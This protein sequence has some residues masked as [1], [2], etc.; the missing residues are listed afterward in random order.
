MYYKLSTS[1]AQIG[2][3]KRD[4]KIKC[5]PPL[6]KPV[7]FANVRTNSLQGSCKSIVVSIALGELQIAEERDGYKVT[8][9]LTW[10]LVSYRSRKML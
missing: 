5:L 2:S 3:T 10:T 8:G 7:K 1:R 6:S 9:D 4:I